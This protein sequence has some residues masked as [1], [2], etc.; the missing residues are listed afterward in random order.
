MQNQCIR[1]ESARYKAG[2]RGVRLEKTL[3]TTLALALASGAVVVGVRTHVHRRLREL[4][5]RRARDD[6]AAF[7]TAL[8]PAAV[9][10]AAVDYD[11]FA[12]R[13]RPI[14]MTAPHPSQR[15]EYDQRVTGPEG[16]ADVLGALLVALGG[17]AVPLEGTDELKTLADFC[18]WLERGAGARARPA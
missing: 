1:T 18:V 4:A 12:T 5:A 8:A 13:E 7:L 16:L 3:L 17:A 2:H 6:Y 11:F 14:G 9:S 10:D 15:V